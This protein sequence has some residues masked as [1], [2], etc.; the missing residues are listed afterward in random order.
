[1]RIMR[2]KMFLRCVTRRIGDDMGK[3]MGHAAL[4][5]GVSLT[6]RAGYRPLYKENNGT[7]W[8]RLLFTCVSRGSVIVFGYSDWGPLL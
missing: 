6:P 8:I 4:Q 1:M 7:V 2:K 3:I 5:E